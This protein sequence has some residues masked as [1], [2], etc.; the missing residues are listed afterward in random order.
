MRHRVVVQIEAHIGGLANLDLHA[1]LGRKGVLGQGQE[2]RLFLQE[3]LAHREARV[4][5]TGPVRGRAQAPGFGLGVEVVEI[6]PAAGGKE[7]VA[8]VPNG[9]F[10][11]A[12]LVAAGHRHRAWLEAVMGGELQ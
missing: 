9:P 12:L 7:A 3:G 10:H 4:L 2:P 8:D 11:P 6:L 5:G 1:L